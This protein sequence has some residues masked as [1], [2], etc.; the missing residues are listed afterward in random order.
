MTPWYYLFKKF[1]LVQVS[2]EEDIVIQLNNTNHKFAILDISQRLD[3]E[4]FVTFCRTLS[5]PNDTRDQIQQTNDLHEE[6]FYLALKYWINSS[7]IK[8]TFNQLINCLKHC[9]EGHL[10]RFMMYRLN[11]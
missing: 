6:Q 5:L 8:A 10:I 4:K 9:N 3:Y 1:F 2:F 7:T 11:T